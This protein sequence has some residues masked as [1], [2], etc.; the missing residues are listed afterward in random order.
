MYKTMKRIGQ[1]FAGLVGVAALLGVLASPGCSNSAPSEN[2]VYVPKVTG[3]REDIQKAEYERD[4]A[5]AKAGGK[6][7]SRAAR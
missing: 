2:V 5:A 4:K 7:A 3:N 6:T 1:G